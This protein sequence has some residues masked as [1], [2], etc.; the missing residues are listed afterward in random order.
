MSCF[1]AVLLCKLTLFSLC[2][3][4]CLVDISGLRAAPT[5]VVANTGTC[6]WI[7]WHAQERMAQTLGV[8]GSVDFCVNASAAEVKEVLGG[9]VGGLHSMLDEH[10]GISVVE[11]MAAGKLLTASRHCQ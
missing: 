2:T 6:L 3:R 10:F 4:H 11:Y 8:A 7:V 1:L 9:A 5:S